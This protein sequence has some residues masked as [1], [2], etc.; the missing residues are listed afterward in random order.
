MPCLLQS[1]PS[2]TRV[3][4]RTQALAAPAAVSRCGQP[5]PPP[6]SAGRAVTTICAGFFARGAN[7][8]T[9]AS[10][11]QQTLVSDG[12]IKSLSPEARRIFRE[13][14]DNII[15]LNKSRLR[16][17]DELKA[18]RQKIAELEDKLETAVA[19]ASQATAQL[20]QLGPR[21]TQDAAAAAAADVTYYSF[22][23]QQQQPPAAAAQPIATDTITVVYE[24][25][26]DAA[27]VHHCVDGG[28][29]TSSPGTRMQNGTQKFP[30]KK[31]L[32]LP[33]RRMEFVINN[34][35]SDWDKP[36]PYGGG[37]SNYVITEPGTYRVKNGKL[38]RL[39]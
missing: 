21:G 20:Q 19:D 18:A 30:N 8:S 31:V 22:G 27:Y 11:T 32:E 6:R 37:N 13:A 9:G 39:G 3:T 14:Q 2:Q 36:N 10:S 34:G 12:A 16:A 1:Q 4:L 29:W 23:A 24:T 26:W 5:L 7:N 25:G 28:A 35:G 33:G 17:L 38:T 15:E